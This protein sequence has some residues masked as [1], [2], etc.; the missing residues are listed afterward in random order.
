MM[1]NLVIKN[2]WT[3]GLALFLVLLLIATKFIQ[4]DFGISGLD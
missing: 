3:F 4:S 2:A 1:P